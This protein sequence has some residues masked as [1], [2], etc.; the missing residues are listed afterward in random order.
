VPC[1]R[2]R[3]TTLAASAAFTFLAALPTPLL[4]QAQTLAA[5]VSPNATSVLPPLKPEQITD[6]Y[7]RSLVADALKRG[8]TPR[9][10]LLAKD[11]TATLKRF[12]FSSLE[13]GKA[14]M[15][16]V[17]VT[18]M[19]FDRALRITTD[20][21][22]AEWQTHIQS[23]NVNEPIR[24]GDVLYLTAWVRAL[25]VTDGKDAGGGR[26][27]NDLRTGDPKTATGIYNG[28]FEI[29]RRW[30]RIHVPMIAEKDL[31]P[32][33]D[34][35]LMF[36]FGQAS[37]AAEIGGIA[38]MNFGSGVDKK[39]LPH[40]DLPLNYAG[41]EPDASWRKAAQARIEKYRKADLAVRVV[42][43]RGKPVSGATVAATMTR[44][45]F[46]FGSSLPTGMLPG[47]NV[48]PWNAD[49]QRTAGAPEAD[50]KRL[51]QE[52]LRLF[53]S[54]TTSVTWTVWE[55]GDGRISQQDILAGLKWL[56]DNG[57]VCFDTQ[58]VYPGTEFTPEKVRALM[59]KENASR[60]GS[61][62]DDYIRFSA[63]QLP[64]QSI[65]I[66]NEIEGRPQYTDVLGYE[67]VPHW[68]RVAKE[69]N[70]AKEVMINGPYQLGGGLVQT[71]GQ[72]GA[73]WP[74]KSEGLQFYFDLISWLRR[75]N[76][77]LDYIGFQNH[78]G[79]GAPG[80]EAVLKT[81]DQFAAFGK[82]IQVTE[83]EVTLQDGSDPDQRRYQADYVRD[84]FTAVFSHPSARGILLQDF[85]QPGAWQ[86]EGASAFF[87]KDWSLNPHGREYERLVL[88]RWRTRAAGKT[89]H[90]GSY[91]TRGFM[92]EYTVTVTAPGR[93]P[94]TVP[95]TLKPA[96]STATVIL[97]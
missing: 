14:K 68:F 11:P 67:A 81:L 92:G 12:S 21:K 5:A 22:K 60:F 19:P 73:V 55:G 25:Q 53:N 96:G 16:E 94:V 35:K 79:I 10:L 86:H 30:T 4:A 34:L 62:V 27:Y 74:S 47:T 3:R 69:A 56:N 87:N 88:N 54:A 95:L 45:A 89:G 26:I 39:A 97:P 78:A 28:D 17:A 46:F 33:D 85:W 37:Q 43:T 48:K 13:E 58:A 41:R 80:P 52:F 84:F 51:Q 61:A 72:R 6:P 38:A 24:K 65:Q 2:R 9:A 77:P 75:K 42:D 82:P 36:T 23:F 15:E 64:V 29:P 20:K 7:Y 63:K 50:K 66:A 83:F 8:L 1:K 44:S 90:A 91:K 49:F 71:A 70:P 32:G 57:I 40:A 59:N 18:G 93:R 76:A 31:G